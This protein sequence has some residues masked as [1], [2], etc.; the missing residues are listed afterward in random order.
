MTGTGD[1][2]NIG[3]LRNI[4]CAGFKLDFF[5]F[6]QTILQGEDI[7]PGELL[8]DALKS[9]MDIMRRF[10][11]KN[12][13]NNCIPMLIGEGKDNKASFIM[14]QAPFFKQLGQLNEKTYLVNGILYSVNINLIADMKE[15][16]IYII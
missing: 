4:L 9:A 11:N 13:A 16:R 5:N 12:S 8:S 2:T 7:I 3:Y 10:S 15:V 1:G 6:L 14:Y